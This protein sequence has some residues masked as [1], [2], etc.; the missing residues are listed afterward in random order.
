M[1]SLKAE[2]HNVKSEGPSSFPMNPSLN[3][4]N[5]LGQARL[6]KA[7]HE[8]WA[9]YISSSMNDLFAYFVL[10]SSQVTF[11]LLICKHSWYCKT[12]CLWWLYVL[13]IF[14]ISF[15]NDCLLN[16]NTLSMFHSFIRSPI[17]LSEAAHFSE[18][19]SAGLGTRRVGS[20][21]GPPI[22][23]PCDFVQ[24]IQGLRAVGSSPARWRYCVKLSKISKCCDLK[25]LL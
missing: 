16:Y 25:K 24:V 11:F 21:R 4:S 23:W 20:R 5:A 17:H 9:I 13:N 8:F 22:T 12:L 6:T 19:K 2:I 7:G 14:K 18:G 10:F 1:I 15:C 3:A